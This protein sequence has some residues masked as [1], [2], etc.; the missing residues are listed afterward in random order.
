M[1]SRKMLLVLMTSLIALSLLIEPVHAQPVTKNE[2]KTDSGL[3]AKEKLDLANVGMYIVAGG[4]EEIFV[5]LVFV[6]FTFAIMA[7]TMAFLMACCGCQFDNGD[8]G[9]L[10]TAISI[11]TACML[12]Q[13]LYENRSKYY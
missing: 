2:K 9:T 13:Q 4:P 10:D 1:A 6:A 3:S 8:N 7:A 11:G 5:R 12:G